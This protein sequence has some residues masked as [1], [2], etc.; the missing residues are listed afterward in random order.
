V[1]GGRRFEHG[2]YFPK[3]VTT[4]PDWLEAPHVNEIWS[5]SDCMSAAPEGWID[6]WR[7]NE[8]WLFDTV[9]LAESVVPPADR[10]AFTI[11]A[12]EVWDRMI[13]EGREVPLPK[14]WRP[15]AG[16]DPSFTTIG[17][18]AVGR[19]HHAFTHSPLS[20]NR[21]ASTFETN[22]ACLFRTA[23]EAIAGA[24]AFSKGN[25]EP[26]PYWVIEVLRRR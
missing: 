2:G 20:C 1:R 16:P 12:Y 21:G 7:H 13:D 19:E 17:F 5:V 6:L 10:E 8:L 24:V 15:L 23:E 25:W 11:V 18:D 22:E 3:R 14:G 9:E 26:G 4:R